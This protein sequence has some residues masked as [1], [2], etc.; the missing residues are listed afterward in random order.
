MQLGKT[1]V[2]IRKEYELTQEDFAKKFNV[3]RQTV[4]NW[5]NEKSYPD[6]LTLIKISDEFGY[7]LDAMLKENPDM[8]EDMNE[9][10]K[11]AKI[12]IKMYEKRI[13]TA[14]IGA[15]ACLIMAVISFITYDVVAMIIWIVALLV[16]VYTIVTYK[17]IKKNKAKKDIY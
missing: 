15:I 2:K 8:T 12:L 17:P 1:I 13:V 7:S 6:L 11:L 10:I 3:T 9:N 5:E 14:I 16:N 4:S